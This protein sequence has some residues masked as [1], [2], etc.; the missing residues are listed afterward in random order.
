MRRPTRRPRAARDP[1]AA[2]LK[3]SRTCCIHSKRSGCRRATLL[4]NCLL[5]SVRFT[6][7]CLQ[8]ISQP[9]LQLQQ[10]L[11]IWALKECSAKID[12]RGCTPRSAHS[13]ASLFT[14]RPGIAMP[15][16]RLLVR[17]CAL[18]A[19]D[20]SLSPSLVVQPLTA[21]AIDFMGETDS[22]I[23]E[24]NVPLPCG[25]GVLAGRVWGF[26]GEGVMVAAAVREGGWHSQAAVRVVQ[27]H[28]LEALARHTQSDKHA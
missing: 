10:F 24:S 11:I 23:S 15:M 26:G 18:H 16:Q 21:A 13:P 7:L 20:C 8:G 25:D 6:L 1:Q 22:G 9:S 19:V 12:G 3:F 2:C 14:A 28:E 27:L 5:L 4:Y 17:P